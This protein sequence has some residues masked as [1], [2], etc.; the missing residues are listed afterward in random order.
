M[1]SDKSSDNDLNELILVVLF[2]KGVKVK[3]MLLAA[4]S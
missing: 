1:A 3:R 2:R 4:M